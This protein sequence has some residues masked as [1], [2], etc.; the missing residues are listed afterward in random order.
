MPLL[1]FRSYLSC[2]FSTCWSFSFIYYLCLLF[3]CYSSFIED[4]FW[5]SS[6]VLFSIEK[7]SVLGGISRLFSTGF[8]CF[9]W[10][11]GLRVI[12]RSLFGFYSSSCFGGSTVGPSQKG[13]TSCMLYGSTKFCWIG[14][15]T[16]LNSIF[17]G[18]T[19]SSFLIYSSRG[20]FSGSDWNVYVMVGRG[21]FF[22]E[23]WGILGEHSEEFIFDWISKY[24]STPLF[25]VSG[26]LF[27]SFLSE[28]LIS[29]KFS[30]DSTTFISL[31]P[32]LW[33]LLSI[34][35]FSCW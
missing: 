16:F 7:G 23:F 13:F 5:G 18:N 3:C 35:S 28:L 27:Y 20:L 29:R 31:L 10:N 12:F 8:S 30:L 21:F 1:T 33:V 9:C 14:E 4:S 17:A 26:D 34:N 25:A 11:F 6:N 22:E 19:E 2:L 32:S 15:G 24:E